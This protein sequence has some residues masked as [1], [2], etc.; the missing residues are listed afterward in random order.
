MNPLVLPAAFGFSL[1]AV[2]AWVKNRVASTDNPSKFPV[3]SSADERRNQ[4]MQ[5]CAA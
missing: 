4:A 2:A 5:L 1:Y 3:I